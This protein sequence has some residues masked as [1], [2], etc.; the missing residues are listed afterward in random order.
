M[1]RV[2]VFGNAGGGKSTLARHLAE[3]TRLPLH[4]L[5]KLQFKPGGDAVPREEYLKAHAELLG[6][7]TSRS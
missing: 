7:D 1:K 2:A 5:D 6:Q 4:V 3:I